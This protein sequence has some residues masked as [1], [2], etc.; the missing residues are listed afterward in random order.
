MKPKRIFSN[1]EKNSSGLG[2]EFGFNLPSPHEIL[3]THKF[4]LK[5][6]I[7]NHMVRIFIKYL[8]K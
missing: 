4:V 1:F 3:S 2:G 5:Y 7:I 6:K 8:Q